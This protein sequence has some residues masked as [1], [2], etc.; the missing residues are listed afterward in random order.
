MD[1]GPLRAV[2]RCLN[3]TTREVAV[4]ILGELAA[5]TTA[6]CWAS[7][8]VSFTFAGRRVGSPTVNIGRLWFALV[9][10]I[11]IH[12][13]MLGSP[14]PLGAPWARYGW[15]GISGLIGFAI[16]DA[17]LFEAL[18]L[19]GP[20]LTMLVMTLVPVFSAILGFL[21]QGE[22]LGIWQIL[23]S[24]VA[25]SGVAS[26]IGEKKPGD[27]RPKHWG[28]G[29]L[30]ALGG[31]VGQA[32]GLL[33]SRLGMEGGFHPVSANSIRILAGTLALTLVACLRG[34]LPG[35]VRRMRDPKAFWHIL[36]G[37]VT[38]P[39]VGVILSLYAI[40]HCS[41]GVSS[42]LMSLSPVLLLAVSGRFFGDRVTV[43]AIF[44]TLVA[45]A[46]AAALFLIP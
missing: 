3:L 27:V 2:Y 28:R 43:R 34:S 33:F 36:A 39:V 44:G 10:M 20:R 18:L 35:H 14:F 12:S 40:A 8:S 21:F 23:A 13:L 6:V 22:R 17:I 11:V 16:G 9:G 15:L 46:G 31:A 45:L 37:S 41:L 7:N 38:G 32:V 42:T 25:L 30:L 1:L 19:L 29:L 26:V 24:L 4:A 5:L